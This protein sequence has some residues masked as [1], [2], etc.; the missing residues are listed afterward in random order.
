MSF[1]QYLPHVHSK[2]KLVLFINFNFSYA[3]VVVVEYS[4]TVDYSVIRLVKYRSLLMITG[5]GLKKRIWR[6]EW[7]FG[8]AKTRIEDFRDLEELNIRNRSH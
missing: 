7:S 4:N 8:G 6:Q 2:M 5:Y 3:I 1:A